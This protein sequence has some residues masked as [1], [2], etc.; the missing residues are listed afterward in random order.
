MAKTHIRLSILLLVLN[1]AELI[2]QW[3]N[4]IAHFNPFE[5][6]IVD[7]GS[8]DT[9]IDIIKSHPLPIK[10]IEHKMGNSFSEQRNIAKQA[11]QG[12]WIL[13]IDADETL[14]E[15][16]FRLIPLLLTDKWAVAFTFPRI[17]IFPDNEHFFGHPNGDL[18]L[19]LFRNLPEIEYVNAVHEQITYRGEIIYPGITRT[20]G[21]WK[22][23]RIKKEIK[24][25]HY[26]YIKSR[27]GLIERGKRWQ[28]FKKASHERGI[29]IGD[30]D[31]FI[32]DQK[33]L[34]IRP[35]NAII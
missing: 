20:K 10:L 18:Q 8:T 16:A 3:L 24:I 34:N 15:N 19:R 4:H 25:L 26:G 30:E 11:C 2:G 17:N 31:S 1:E 22:W 29:E 9:T 35:L 28:K 23:C 14:T 6:I 33:K 21:L 13:Q 12:D 7:G 27:E 5:V 32:L